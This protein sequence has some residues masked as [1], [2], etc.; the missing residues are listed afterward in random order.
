MYEIKATDY[1][2]YRQAVTNQREG[3]LVA[4]LMTRDRKFA[5]VVT[6]TLTGQQGGEHRGYAGR[7]PCRAYKARVRVC[8]TPMILMIAEEI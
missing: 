8:V 5:K 7:V 6:L 4:L 3:E 1:D 2:A